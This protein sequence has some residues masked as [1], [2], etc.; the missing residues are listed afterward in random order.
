LIGDQKII[1]G[2]A[3]SE[4]EIKEKFDRL[5]V[6]YEEAMPFEG[7]DKYDEI[8]VKYEGQIVCRKRR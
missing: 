5:R 4:L 8:S 6:F 1:F 3:N 7:W 2:S